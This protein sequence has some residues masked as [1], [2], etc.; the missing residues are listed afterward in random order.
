MCCGIRL[1]PKK[2]HQENIVYFEKGFRTH[3]HD[4]GRYLLIS[5]LAQFNTFRPTMDVSYLKDVN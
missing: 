3:T 1:H 2:I 4:W 5:G